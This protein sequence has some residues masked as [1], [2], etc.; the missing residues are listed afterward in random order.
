MAKAIFRLDER[1]IKNGMYQVRMRISNNGD[2][3]WIPTGV[4]VERPCFVPDSM[5]EPITTK[6]YMYREKVATLREFAHKYDQAVFELERD[7]NKNLSSMSAKEIRTYII[8]ERTCSPMRAQKVS[9]SGR[10]D[11]MDWF[12][13]F[14]QG[15]DNEN[16]RKHY[17]YVWRLLHSYC[18]DR[19]I[20]RLYFNDIDYDRLNDIRSWVLDG[21]EDVTRYKVESYMHSAYKEA[22]RCHLISRD[23]DPYDDYKVERVRANDSE[24]EVIELEDLRRFLS[25]DLTNQQ[26]YEGL[27]RARDILWASFC[28]CGANLIDLYHMP[29][30]I[31]NEVVYIRHKNIGRTRRPVHT[32]IVDD[33][34]YIVERYAGQ[35]YM[36][37]FQEQHS[38]YYTF[39]RRINE[40]CERLSRLLGAKVNMQLI[41]RTWATIAGMEA[42]DWHIV[43]KSLGHID[44]E[45]TDKNYQR[46]FWQRAAQAN[47]RVIDFVLRGVKPNSVKV[48]KI[49]RAA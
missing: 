26:G 29:K 13:R 37:N 48:P 45:V 44:K 15:K 36:F 14:G 11:F 42:V 43:N 16:T 39:Q 27:S 32:Q 17:A 10:I 41:R 40:R 8:G 7:P 23:N 19:G 21:R 12:D 4:W 34:D 46:F 28:M 20:D 25:M 22:Q 9:H 24:I 35:Q 18:Q 5:Y 1:T 6:A 3:T 47:Q 33:I 2:S 38:N 30:Q 31:G 49:F